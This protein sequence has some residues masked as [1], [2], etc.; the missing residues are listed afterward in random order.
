MG[1]RRTSK[2]GCC[3]ETRSEVVAYSPSTPGGGVGPQ[4]P[5]GRL[6][7]ALPLV[8]PKVKVEQETRAQKRGGEHED[9][10]SST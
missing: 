1:S 4:P 8:S 10:Q 5:S 7:A 9:P 6:V 3:G 2:E